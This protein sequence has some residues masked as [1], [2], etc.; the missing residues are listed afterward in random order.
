MV[1]LEIVHDCYVHLGIQIDPQ[2]YYSKENYSG[3]IDDA[4]LEV[5]R[6]VCESLIEEGFDEDARWNELRGRV[7][8]CKINH[9]FFGYLGK[10]TPEPIM[11]EH[12]DD[13]A[14]TPEERGWLYPPAGFN[15]PD[16]FQAYIAGRRGSAAS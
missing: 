2:Q 4:E 14:Y 3:T 8:E 10:S 1:L 12:Y 16:E 13:F 6:W 15:S 5:C 7:A 11:P 9:L